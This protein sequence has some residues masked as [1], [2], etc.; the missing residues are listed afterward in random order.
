LSYSASHFYLLLV[1]L[2]IELRAWCLLD[3]HS[4]TWAMPFT[5]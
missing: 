4:T 5:P 3:K 2:G 1:I